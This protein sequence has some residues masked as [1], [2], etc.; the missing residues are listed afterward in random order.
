M[1]TFSEKNRLRVFDNRVLRKIL[2]PKRDEIR[3]NWIRLHEGRLLTKCYSGDQIKKNGMGGACMGERGYRVGF[4]WGEL[5][6][7][8]TRPTLRWD[9]NIKVYLHEIG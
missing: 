9:D 2:R 7:G 4:W 1:V 6:E 3:G 5:R 8:D